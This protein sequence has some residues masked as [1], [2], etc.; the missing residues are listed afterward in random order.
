MRGAPIA[1]LVLALSL[2]AAGCDRLRP[3]EKPPSRLIV[4]WTGSDTG[5]MAA[6]AVAEWCD[7]LRVLEIRGVRG[8]S[9]LAMAIYPLDRV[10]ADSYPVMLPD[11][12]DS[13]RPSAAVGARWFAE[14]SVK[15]F[16]GDRGA[17]IVEQAS[18]RVSGR[19]RARMRSVTDGSRLE[20]EGTFQRIAVVPATRGCVSR[21]PAQPPDT[22]ID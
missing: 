15:G 12:A 9:G 10:Q 20:L 16:Q 13:T 7:S 21:P 11:R 22:G 17:V 8:D 14:T 1:L 19:F 2:P 5:A 6:K 3:G 18:G 4:A